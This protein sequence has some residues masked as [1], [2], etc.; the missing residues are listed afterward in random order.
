M[1]GKCIFVARI[2][3]IH[4][5]LTATFLVSCVWALQARGFGL[6]E[7]PPTTDGRLV[8]AVDFHTHTVFS[9]GFVWPSTRVDE[10][11]LE[12]LAGIALTDHLEWQPHRDD[13]PNPD[14]NRSFNLAVA[15]A[16]TLAESTHHLPVV[17]INGTEITRGVPPGHLNAVFLKDVN[18]LLEAK[19]PV[20]S[21][22]ED[23]SKLAGDDTPDHRSSV[24][25]AL[26]KAHEQ[27]GFI[28]LNHPFNNFDE[29]GHLDDF[30]LQLIKQGLT[31]GVEVANGQ[32]YVEAAFQ[33]A[34]DRNLAIIG[35]ADLHDAASRWP[36]E[37][38]EA[39]RVTAGDRAHRTV[40]LVL[41]QTRDEPGIH[42]ALKKRTTVAL[43]SEQ[44]FGRE[45]DVDA[46]VSS[47]LVYRISRPV[48]KKT[49]PNTILI[50][51]LN[52]STI[53]FVVHYIGARAPSTASRY[54]TV[55]SMGETDIEFWPP[56]SGTGAP[57]EP[58][59]VE[60]M[61]A[62]IAPQKHAVLALRT[63]SP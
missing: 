52:R 44:L 58:V 21:T 57:I 61:N 29:K 43:F 33:L 12:G 22:A 10:A 50:T 28:I 49:I 17:V 38:G 4:A 48:G 30:N 34:L 9:D 19:Y 15:E 46:I 14:R 54:W 24:Y 13:I 39:Y 51:L 8:L 45:A 55:P 41:S 32:L 16:K 42:E 56:E 25:N 63:T 60:V 36:Y 3:W 6:I 53:P 37:G 40:T 18:A 1:I 62:F 5:V 11:D 20:A 35:A 59:T 47:A 23:W 27:G 31:D 7:F 26:R 2:E